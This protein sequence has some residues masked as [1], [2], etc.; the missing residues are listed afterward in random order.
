MLPCLCRVTRPAPDKRLALQAGEKHI[1]LLEIVS[2][3][4]LA[5]A[6]SLRETYHARNVSL[7][8]RR[9]AEGA[10][11]TDLANLTALV[12]VDIL[13]FCQEIYNIFAERAKG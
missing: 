10:E 3:K 11:Y 13:E 5:I 2:A 4:F 8:R 6:F 7:Y 12:Y 9:L 1:I